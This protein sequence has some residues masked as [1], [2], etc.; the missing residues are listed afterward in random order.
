MIYY[1]VKILDDIPEDMTGVSATPTS[2]HLFDISEDA[3]KLSQY[4]A[5]LFHHF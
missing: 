1:I 4:D 2:Q 5:D 3:T